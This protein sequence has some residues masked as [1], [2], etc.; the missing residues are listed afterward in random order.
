MNGS[1]IGDSVVMALLAARLERESQDKR[2]SGRTTRHALRAALEAIIIGQDGGTVQ[3]GDHSKTDQGNIELALKVSAI[4]KALGVSHMMQGA[5]IT[6][7]P[8][9]S[10]EQAKAEE[11]FP[12]PAWAVARNEN[13][14]LVVGAQLLT[15]DGRRH[16]N[17]FLVNDHGDGVYCVQTEAGNH[18]HMNAMEIEEGFY[19]GDWIGDLDEIF[20][21][22]VK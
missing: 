18:M 8:L 2:G 6:V 21:K 14:A 13:R 10:A 19:V 4:L 9:P 1:S 22:F 7:D 5:S 11:Q 12:T 17:A 16:G 15:K 3:L 20:D